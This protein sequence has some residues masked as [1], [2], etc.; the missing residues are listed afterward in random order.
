[1]NINT[2]S[3]MNLPLEALQ[4]IFI[5]TLEAINKAQPG[6]QTRVFGP[7]RTSARIQARYQACESKFLKTASGDVTALDLLEGVHKDTFRYTDI[8][9]VAPRLVKDGIIE[10]SRHGRKATW[11]LKTI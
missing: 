8:L 9:V 4:K 2:K 7:P 11:H 1:M 5:E 6:T 10:E 3:V